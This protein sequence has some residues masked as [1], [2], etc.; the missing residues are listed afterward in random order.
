MEEETMKDRLLAFAKHFGISVGLFEKN[1]G[2]SNGYFRQL[3]YKPKEAVLNR[4]FERYPELNRMWVI[5]GEGSMFS[6]PSPEDGLDPKT[7]EMMIEMQKTQI[8]YL[9]MQIEI[10]DRQ[11]EELIQSIK[12]LKEWKK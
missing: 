10:K 11:I 5:C 12:E 6:P 4:I 7:R 3:R 9:K 8:A 2:V 1:I